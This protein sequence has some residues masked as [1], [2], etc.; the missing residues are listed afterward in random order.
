M[1]GSG[2]VAAALVQGLGVVA[3]LRLEEGAALLSRDFGIS[4]AQES[5]AVWDKGSA[6]A[7]ALKMMGLGCRVSPASIGEPEA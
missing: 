3:T 5:V 6:A 7:R 2:V 4:T 1:C